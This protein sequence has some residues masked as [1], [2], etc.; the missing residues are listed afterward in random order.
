MLGCPENFQFV[1]SEDLRFPWSTAVYRVNLGEGDPENIPK[2]IAR[3]SRQG[4]SVHRLWVIPCLHTG[5]APIYWS[6]FTTFLLLL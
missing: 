1:D 5:K 6:L 2:K 4:Q 3:N